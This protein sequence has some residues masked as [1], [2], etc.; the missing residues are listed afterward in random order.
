M[1]QH[2][3]IHRDLKLANILL[4]DKSETPSVKIG[5]L[6]LALQLGSGYKITKRVGSVGFMAPE[7]LFKRPYDHKADIY[8]LGVIL[9]ILISTNP[10]FPLELF[11]DDNFDQLMSQQ[12]SFGEIIWLSYSPKVI[13]L[14][15]NMLS[16]DPYSR[17]DINMV[18]NHPWM[19]KATLK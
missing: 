14:L 10:P 3:L 16:F 18:L 17:Y 8:S 2:R 7:V 15:K 12:V 4:S 13:D 11:A 1:H 6:S 5:G 9:Y 19:T